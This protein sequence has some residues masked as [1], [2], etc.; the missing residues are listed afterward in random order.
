MTFGLSAWTSLAALGEQL[1][2]EGFSVDVL[3]RR[4]RF[5]FALCAGVGRAAAERI[6][7]IFCMPI[8]TRRFPML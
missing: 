6:A 1:R 2:G 4:P 8:N 7:W 3:G 5:G